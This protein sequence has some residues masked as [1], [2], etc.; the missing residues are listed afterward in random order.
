MKSQPRGQN[1]TTSS[2]WLIA[3]VT[4]VC[5]SLAAVAWSTMRDIEHRLRERILS[6]NSAALTTTHRSLNL[7]MQQKESVVESAAGAPEVRNAAT[8]LIEPPRNPETLR[9]SSVLP[10]LRSFFD[11]MKSPGV[12]QGF[13][14][15]APDGTI[16]GAAENESIGTRSVLADNRRDILSRVFSGETLL[17][18][19]TISQN[20]SSAALFI[21]SPVRSNSNSVIAALALPLDVVEFNSLIEL[22]HVLTTGKT[23]AFD[24][25]GTV[26]NVKG[27]AK[28]AAELVNNKDG[29]SLTGY[30]DYRGVKVMGVW[31]WDDKLNIGLATEVDSSEAMTPYLD[32]R[33]AIFRIIAVILVII[34]LF[35]SV[36]LQIGR[37]RRALSAAEEA[38]RMKSRFLANMSHEIRTPM[39]GVIGL[40]ELVLTGDLTPQL[41]E[42][43]ETIKSSAESLMGI[44]NDI[45]DTSKLESGQ[46]ELELVPFDL[47]AVLLSTMRVASRPAAARGNELA[48][49]IAPDVPQIV[50]G[51]SLRVRQIL[52]N[53]VGNATKFTEH[54]EIELSV[55]RNGE[56]NG[57][58]ALKFAVRDTGI[59]IP[60]DKIGQIFE[61]FSQADASVTRKYGG[62]G[63]GLTISH[64]LVELMGGKITVSSLKD[65]GSTF[66]FT[67]P[68]APGTSVAPATSAAT[69]LVGRTALVVDDNATNRRIARSIVEQT[70]MRVVEATNTDDA[71]RLLKEG[72][73][74]KPFDIALLDLQMPGKSGFDLLTE[75]RAE[76][77]I[78]TKF[79]IL[80]S[81]GG[82]GDAERARS[83]GVGAF[84]T[85]PVSRQELQERISE[86]LSG[87]PHRD[88]DAAPAAPQPQRLLHLLVAEDNPVNQ[89]VA[90]AMLQRLGHTVEVVD[91]G[92]LAVEAVQNKAFDAVLMDIEMPRLDGYGATERIRQIPR[93]KELPII[94]LTAH[95][96]AE[97]RERAMAVGM[98]AF[99]T[100]P[101]KTTDLINALQG[102]GTTAIQPERP[103]ATRPENE[104][105]LPTVDIEGL[106]AEWRSA[107]ILHKMN[108]I[109]Q[110]FIE[111]SASEFSRMD[112]ALSSNDLVNVGLIAHKMKSG[113]AALH[114][115]KLAKQLQTIE[116]AAK[117]KLDREVDIQ[118]L[119]IEAVKEWRAARKV[120]SESRF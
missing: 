41:R 77:S 3:L 104:P 30:L 65:K 62:T 56:V 21:A 111:E 81:S 103:F 59:G 9:S 84:L 119:V 72:A 5:V 57:I 90:L 29:A 83:L 105:D 66:S 32:S 94:G 91:D 52:T 101:F 13:F 50:V 100:K 19:P 14:L 47:H 44:L 7:W 35:F 26:L 87:T 73:D 61:E 109:I 114:V 112:E 17:F 92:L 20:T 120:F 11:G 33:R 88:K 25:D 55:S 68:L 22:G 49:D 43:M 60:E 110:T 8:V 10:K 34:L 79:V 75:V 53:L 58:P 76:P 71:V 24:R 54:G 36:Y 28:V 37:S 80:T 85:K 15:I 107:G 64:R 95:A 115:K 16:I 118:Q 23:S 98:N 39:N 48:L 18:P 113:A 96:M 12:R 97:A 70:G 45:L 74:Q 42:N 78:S 46:F 6:F 1:K 89:R 116:L 93:L 69:M 86:V 67:I 4:L 106:K 2:K 27:P 99:V 51:D 102:L 63:L 31:V 117:G 82:F 40:T 38:S 108:E